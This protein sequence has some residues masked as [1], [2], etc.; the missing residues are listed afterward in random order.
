[1]N[2]F[3]QY[4]YLKLQLSLFETQNGTQVSHPGKIQVETH[5]PGELLLVMLLVMLVIHLQSIG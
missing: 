4:L 5:E 2:A 3:S 1:V